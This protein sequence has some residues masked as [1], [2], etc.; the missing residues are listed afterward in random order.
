MNEMR[1]IVPKQTDK[2]DSAVR[3]LK[4]RS[5]NTKSGNCHLK[6]LD[7]HVKGTLMV[8]PH[9]RDRLPRSYRLS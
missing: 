3:L 2:H 8:V 1:M 7:D 6:D 4:G 9:V 5:V